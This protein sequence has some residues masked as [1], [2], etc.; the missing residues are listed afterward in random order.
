[1]ARAGDE[2]DIGY[3]DETQNHEFVSVGRTTAW[4]WHQGAQLQWLGNSDKIVYNDFDGRQHVARIKNL[5]GQSEG[6]LTRPVAAT[7]PD[8]S[9]ALSYSFARLRGSPHGYAY[10]NGIDLEADKQIP[11]KDG[12]WL[13]KT[14]CDEA[15]LLFTVDQIA[16]MEHEP[17]MNGAFHYF[18]HCQFSRRGTRFKFFIAG[19]WMITGSG[20]AIRLILMEGVFTYFQLRAWCP[21]FRGEAEIGLLRTLGPLLVAMGIMSLGT[22]QT[23]FGKLAEIVSA[24]T[25]TPRCRMMDVGC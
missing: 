14:H 16:R 7:S 4:N 1:M 6:V 11:Q 10:A 23:M 12:L 21:M 5:R 20:R 19:R 8:G 24:P 25:G 17:S 3:L 15:R 18:S 9:M 22:N 2:L 13:L